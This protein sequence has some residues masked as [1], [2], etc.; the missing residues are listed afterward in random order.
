DADPRG[1][2]T[3]H[4]DAIRGE[5]ATAQPGTVRRTEVQGVGVH[6]VPA[7]AVRLHPGGV[8]SARHD[9]HAPAWGMAEQVETRAVPTRR[10]AVGQAGRGLRDVGGAAGRALN[11]W[12]TVS[13]LTLLH[14][15]RSGTTAS[16][17]CRCQKE[18]LPPHV[19]PPP[20]SATG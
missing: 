7:V 13:H 17:A 4:A 11:D 18:S 16:M 1:V 12:S 20:G 19:I 9:V 6:T 15:S 8:G 10:R 3:V 5:A 2:R 14:G